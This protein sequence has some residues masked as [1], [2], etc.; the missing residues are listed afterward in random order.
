VKFLGKVGVII[1]EGVD[2]IIDRLMP[3]AMG[4]DDDEKKVMRYLADRQAE[5]ARLIEEAEQKYNDALKVYEAATNK[6]DRLLPQALT[7]ADDL[8]A[9]DGTTVGRDLIK[10]VFFDNLGEYENAKAEVR[11]ASARLQFAHDW[12]QALR[13][14]DE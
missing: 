10:N 4:M 9:V 3:N 8:D 12:L 11:R 13:A 6:R 2:G 14:G 1:D 5:R 7:A